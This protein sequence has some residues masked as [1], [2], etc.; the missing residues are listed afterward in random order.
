MDA[1]M[2]DE[3]NAIRKKA[4]GLWVPI[5]EGELGNVQQMNRAQRRAWAKRQRKGGKK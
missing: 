2:A 1:T 3:L 4:D 5:P